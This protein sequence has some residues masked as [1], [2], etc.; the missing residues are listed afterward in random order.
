[1]KENWM[2]MKNVHEYTQSDETKDVANSK[3]LKIINGI[4]T[5]PKLTHSRAG[6]ERSE[7]QV[8]E[9]KA[10]IKKSFLIYW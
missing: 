6:G 9:N 8:L 10:V 5:T 3:E 7:L 4:I 1:M 2:T